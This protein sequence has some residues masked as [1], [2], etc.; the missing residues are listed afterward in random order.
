VHTIAPPVPAPMIDVEPLPERELE[1]PETGLRVALFV[2][3]A[4]HA[5]APACQRFNR[6]ALACK[7]WTRLPCLAP[8]PADVLLRSRTNCRGSTS[9]PALFVWASNYIA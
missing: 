5:P 4:V 8:T 2:G 7:P 6:R 3:G 9:T 1:P